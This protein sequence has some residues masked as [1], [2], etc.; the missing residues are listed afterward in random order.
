MRQRLDIYWGRARN[1]DK[2]LVHL[3]NCQTSDQNKALI[4]RWHDHLFTTGSGA[5]RVAKL[6]SQMRKV[7]LHFQKDLDKVIREDIERVIAM[8]NRE[9]NWS[10]ATKADYRRCIKQFYRWFNEHDPR[11]DAG[12]KQAMSL[13]TFLD[14]HVSTA[15][16]ANSYDYSEIINDQDLAL[17][18]EK[19][20]GHIREKAILSMLHEGGF[21]AGE[22]LNIQIRDLEWKENSVI[23]VVDGKTGRRRVPLVQSMGLL[24]RWLE[25]HPCKDDPQSYLWLGFNRKFLHEP[26]KHIGLSKLVDRCFRKAGCAKRHNLHWFRHSRAT[27]VARHITEVMMCK[28]FGW[29]IGSKQVRCYVHANVEQLE[30]A[31]LSMNGLKKPE[32]EEDKPHKCRGCQL[33]NDNGARYCR[34]CGR[35]LNVTIMLEDEND[36]QAATNE[37]F[38]FFQKVMADPKL[39]EMFANLVADTSEKDIVCR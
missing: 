19:G 25:E 10:S 27:I 31:V 16:K 18:I 35:A 20:C 29:S 36:K 6:S 21:R 37:A 38:E 17:V 3:E 13:Y 34:R 8:Y 32:E 7:V 39:R 15:H 23:V 2:E 12:D 28:F 4:K 33:I 1:F 24:G 5:V 22:F 30:D 11:M 26:L 9:E 14:R